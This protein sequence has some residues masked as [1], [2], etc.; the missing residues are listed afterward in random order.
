MVPKIK[1]VEFGNITVDDEVFDKD[2]FIL[3]RDG[4][5]RIEKSHSSDLGEFHSI[6]L[7]EP[8]LIIFGTGFSNCF[9]L[10][11]AIKKEADKSRIE[12]MELPT[13]DAIKKFQEL[14]K[15]GRRVAARIHTTC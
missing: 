1:K 4:F 8:D 13:P 5:E 9:K 3:F 14:V 6:L 15:I 10:S 12:L 11:E 7:R 2:D